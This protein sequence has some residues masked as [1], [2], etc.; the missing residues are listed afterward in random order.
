MHLLHCVGIL[1]CKYDFNGTGPPHIQ[2]AILCLQYCQ[3]FFSVISHL[4]WIYYAQIPISM[5]SCTLPCVA[6]DQ[7][8]MVIFI[9]YFCILITILSIKYSGGRRKKKF[10]CA[11]HLIEVILFYRT[12]PFMYLCSTS[13]YSLDT[14]K[15]VAVF[16]T[17]I[18][19]RF[20]AVI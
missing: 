20:N 14:D 12:V 9:S 11:S 19:P 5:N 2:A 17:V 4:S 6:S 7:H 15:V 16:Y 18:F 1:Q 13:S 8:F 3:P 10:T